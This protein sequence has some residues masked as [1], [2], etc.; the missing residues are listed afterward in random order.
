MDL[1]SY[2]SDDGYT[3][4]PNDELE[5]QER[6]VSKRENKGVP[7]LRLAYHVQTSMAQE[8]ESWTKMLELPVR[9][10]KKWMSA[11]EEE[12]KSLNEHQV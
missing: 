12:M 9:E 2:T 6:R 7:P 1:D 10:R 4:P 8:P 5:I 11:A 3:T